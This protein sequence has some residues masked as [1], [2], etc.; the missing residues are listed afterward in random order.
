M[1]KKKCV[2]FL[3]GECKFGATC[4]F[5]HG[6]ENAVLEKNNAKISYIDKI[7]N[8]NY[9]RCS[10]CKERKPLPVLECG[11]EVFCEECAKKTETCPEK[12]SYKWMIV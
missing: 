4:K 8:S 3:S 9:K 5:F 6:K 11:C 12:H 10:E 7:I 1:E 2:K